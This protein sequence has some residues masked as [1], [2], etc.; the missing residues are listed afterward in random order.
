MNCRVSV[1]VPPEG[2]VTMFELSITVGPVPEITIG[3]TVDV[4]EIVPANP[5]IAEK[6]IVEVVLSPA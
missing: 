1:W 5:V 3:E 6:V 2:N 4:T